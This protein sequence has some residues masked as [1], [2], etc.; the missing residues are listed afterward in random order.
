MYVNAL[1]NK[2]LSYLAAYRSICT[3]CAELSCSQCASLR[4]NAQYCLTH[5]VDAWVCL[6]L[7][8]IDPFECK[9]AAEALRNS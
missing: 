1:D 8:A 7:T 3:P 9:S 2:A 6:R 5:H 4:V